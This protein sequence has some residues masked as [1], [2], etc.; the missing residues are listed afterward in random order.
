ML[1]LMDSGKLNFRIN[2]LGESFTDNPPI[3]AEAREKLDK[4]IDHFGYVEQKSQY[5]EILK[6]S[7]IVVSTANHEFFG[8]AMCVT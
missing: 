8:V 6:A 5:Y 2:V 1:Q 4:F 7:D 3:F